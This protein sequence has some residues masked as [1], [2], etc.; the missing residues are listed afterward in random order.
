MPMMRCLVWTLAAACLPLAACGHLQL[1]SDLRQKQGETALSAWHAVDLKGFFAAERTNEAKILEQELAS[2][3][4][5][6]VVRREL[7]IRKLARTPVRSLPKVYDE[8]LLPL[9][10]DDPNAVTPQARAQFEEALRTARNAHN[11]QQALQRQLDRDMSFLQE[12]GAPRF[13]CAQLLDAD[14]AIVDAWK[15]RE[16]ARAA[17]AGGRLRDVARHCHSIAA[18]EVAARAAVA[19][20]TGGRIQTIASAMQAAQQARAQREQAADTARKA[21]EAALKEYNAEV[22][23]AKAGTSTVEKAGA[24]AVKAASALQRVEQLQNALSE[25]FVSEER[26]KKIEAL[27]ASLKAGTILDT[28]DA[29]KAQIAISFF[30]TIADDIRAIRQARKGRAAVPLLIQRDIDM[31]RLNAAKARLANEQQDIALSSAELGA[32]LVQ[33]N[34]YVNARNRLFGEP[35]KGMPAVVTV[36]PAGATVAAAWSDLQ[37]DQR[38]ALLESTSLYLDAFGRQQAEADAAAT[39]RFALAKERAIAMSEINAG[40][41]SSLIGATVD[42]AAEFGA[43]GIKASD[44]APILNLLGLLYIG[45]GVNQ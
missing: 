40:M 21:Y 45:R 11:A 44:I 23:S 33:A 35:V 25:E 34:T 24:A 29:S 7:E 2:T 26:I 19:R 18:Q 9:V 6:A 42:Q 12:M 39:R 1:H 5:L 20:L 43:L 32:T 15:T 28:E 8:A 38:I 22:E 14:Q 36:A 37:P 4:K 3:E 10:L 41:W 30:P 16:P 13:S 27:L 17:A 31:A